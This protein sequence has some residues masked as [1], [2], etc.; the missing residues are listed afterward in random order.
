M[1]KLR[2]LDSICSPKLD[3]SVLTAIQDCARCKNFGSTHLYSLLEPITRQR[4]FE[5]LVGDYLSLP[6]GKGGWKGVGLYVDAFTRHVWAY[7]YKKSPTGKT[8]TDSLGDIIRAFVAPN[9]F[10]TDGGS[11]FDNKEVR[12]FCTSHGTKTHVIATYSPWVNGLVEGTNKLLLHILKRLCSPEHGE[13]NE[14]KEV[15]ELSEDMPEKWPEFLDDAI[16]ELNRRI[17]PSLQFSPKELLLGYPINTGTPS[18]ETI[19]SD[20][21]EGDVMAHLAYVEQQ[22]LDGYDNTIRHAIQ[23]K[24]LFDKRIRAK[25][26]GEVVYK[27]GQLVQVY[28]SDLDYT[29]KVERKMIS[30]WSRPFRVAE[31]IVNSYRLET[32][33][34]QAIEGEF[35]ARRLRGFQPREGTQLAREQKEFEEALV[36]QRDNRE[37]S[38]GMSDE[39]AAFL[40]MGAHGMGDQRE[41]G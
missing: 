13:D 12:E 35:H 37:R 19:T 41:A 38:R 29:F 17:L 36:K 24:T 14:D 39:D 7:K 32:L 3:H 8:T 11:H 2:L 25:K 10:M 5:L 18:L 9:I 34:G 16:A 15:A 30:K 26:S 20:P 6:T 27:Q 33:D 1:I 4:P 21:T 22:R 28:R 31:R 40:K 23:R